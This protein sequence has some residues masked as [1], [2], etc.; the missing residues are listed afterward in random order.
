MINNLK[1]M[2]LFNY[3]FSIIYCS[4]LLSCGNSTNPEDYSDSK[5]T[6]SIFDYKN[7]FPEEGTYSKDRGVLYRKNE[8]HDILPIVDYHLIKANACYNFKFYNYNGK[9]KINN[10]A[11]SNVYVKGISSEIILS[12]VKKEDV[13]DFQYFYSEEYGKWGNATILVGNTFV[14]DVIITPLA[15]KYL[16]NPYNNGC[17]VF[18]RFEQNSGRE[19]KDY[20]FYGD[21]ITET[22]VNKNYEMINRKPA[23][24]FPAGNNDW[25]TKL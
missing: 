3:L 8:E 5:K 12:I 11:I 21:T 20:L 13:H 2:K 1:I 22:I 17:L 4:V 15:V 23:I 14:K 16:S 6:N 19:Y 25:K 7:Y 9:L 10:K 24:S 18:V